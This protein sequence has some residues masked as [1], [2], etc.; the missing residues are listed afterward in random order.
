M[1]DDKWLKEIRNKMADFESEEPAGLWQQIEARHKSVTEERGRKPRAII[2]S[3][4]TAA[5]VLG[6][7]LFGGIRLL[8]EENHVDMTPVLA[9]NQDPAQAPAQTY[10][11]PATILAMKNSHPTAIARQ[12]PASH[13][14]A[15]IHH[16][17]TPATSGV[18]GG[19][20]TET[21]DEQHVTGHKEDRQP[22]ESRPSKS[23]S[24]RQTGPSD[25]TAEDY[26]IS[27]PIK[28]SGKRFSVGIFTSGT[29]GNS[30]SNSGF[31]NLKSAGGFW[32][33]DPVLNPDNGTKLL[34]SA[35]NANDYRN[36]VFK[37]QH[38]QPIRFGLSVSYGLT[39]RLSIE[40]GL[41]YSRLSSDV[42]A[43]DI[44]YSYAGEQTLH[45]IG[46]PLNLKY[47]FAS[48][49]SFDFYASAGALA[50]KCVSGKLS[51][52]ESVNGHQNGK[53]TA[54]IHEKQLQY[55]LNAA[56]GVQLRL[57]DDLGIYVEPGISYYPDNGSNINSIHKERPLN[58]DLNL[59][60]RLSLGK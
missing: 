54:D 48:W 9:E 10:A 17:C 22:I 53:K 42:T 39:P 55:S 21:P 29:I 34:S 25:A 19:D 8:R 1:N 11:P 49:H 27:R 31:T 46:V 24:E 33:D 5:A 13:P 51:G 45:Y 15:E 30:T 40:S 4:L 14:A 44:T 2:L 23:I 43:G 7:I 6:A 60:L 36:Q 37:M 32:A 28:H 56:G 20:L 3:W 50:E 41:S 57:T 16:G 58:F 26:T 12:T 38:H 47:R 18:D 35:A 59:G 52:H